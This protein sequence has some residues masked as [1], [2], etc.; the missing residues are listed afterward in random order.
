M[1]IK[2]FLFFLKIIFFQNLELLVKM[3]LQI[4]FLNLFL[5]LF[6][7]NVYP[8][9]AQ[10]PNFHLK[11]IGEKIIQDTTFQNTA[12][13]G[14]SGLDMSPEGNWYVISDSR[15]A[16]KGAKI[17]Q[18]KFDYSSQGI[19]DFR[20]NNVLIIN[21]LA[22]KYTPADTN[23]ANA[24]A[25]RYDPR[26]KHFVWTSE[27]E[28]DPK[29]GNVENPYMMETNAEGKCFGKIR[30]PERLRYYSRQDTTGL[31]DN[32]SIESL[33]LIP[34]SDEAWVSIEEPLYQDK[35]NDADKNAPS[36]I[37]IVKMNRKT[38]KSLI[39]YAYIIEKEEGNGV[40]EILAIDQKNLLVLERA[41]SP[42]TKL[43]TIRL[44]AINFKGASNIIHNNSLAKN[45]DYQP[46]KK[47]LIFDFGTL[48]DQKIVKRVDNIEGMAW[49][50][51]LPNGNRT[52]VFVSDDNFNRK[53]GQITQLI[54]MEVVK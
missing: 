4:F 53:R 40:V 50:K 46:V 1:K 3:K 49:G 29:T 22:K 2:G 28:N 10:K 13:G 42:S 23:L 38:G 15:L 12:V 44:F 17:Y 16:M 11:F 9:L 47:Q 48:R 36:P 33:S 25:I 21:D 6:F 45:A 19:Q 5:W 31:R 39:E 14:F 34:N 35:P 27:G 52:L 41:Y 30:L 32:K 7:G 18:F 20:F 43:N 8:S 54:V 51:T 24:E 26:S 37:R